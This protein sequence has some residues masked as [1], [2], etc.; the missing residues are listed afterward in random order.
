LKDG[1]KILSKT[2]NE[3]VVVIPPV[4][5]LGIVVIE[6]QPVIIAIEV[7][8]VRIAIAVGYVCHATRTTANLI[9]NG[10]RDSAVYYSTSAMS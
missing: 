8:H 9:C 4:Q 6:P 1:K 5:R 7:K 3:L 10:K 2:K